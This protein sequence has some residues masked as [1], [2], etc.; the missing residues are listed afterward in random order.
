MSWKIKEHGDILE[1]EYSD[2]ILSSLLSYSKIWELY[3]GNNGKAYLPEIK[4]MSN[5]EN[6]RRIEFSEYHYT[7]LESAILLDIISKSDL[8]IDS[9]KDYLN[10]L[11][12]L[13]AFYAHC[14]RIRD[15]LIKICN[16]FLSK[17]ETESI[18][19]GL[20]EYYQQR[21][22]VLH[23]KKMPY[24]INEGLFLT[25]RIKGEEEE[26]NNSW[27]SSKKWDDFDKND[28]VFIDYFL[29]ETAQE[30][31]EKTNQ[32]LYNLFEVVKN[33]MDNNNLKLPLP[34]PSGI[35]NSEGEHGSSGRSGFSFTQN[36]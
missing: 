15:C 34:L 21:N 27:S 33:F 11:K 14:G 16:L 1:K 13:M 7:C 30:V 35:S 18:T 5:E 22:N 24:S 12:D 26:N 29:K 2:F 6:E 8:R 36:H 19:K 9:I 32:I 10:V 23:G 3:V 25:P 28:L 31:F 4:N 20:E 17:N